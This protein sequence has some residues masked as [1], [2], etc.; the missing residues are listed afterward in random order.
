MKKTLYVAIREVL[1]TITTKGFIFGVL[2]TPALILAFIFLIPR[3]VIKGPPKI[4]GQVAIVDPTGDVAASL[5]AYLTPEQFVERR[6]RAQQQIRE[7]AQNEAGGSAAANAVLG[8]SLNAT[9]GEVPQIST[10]NLAIGCDLEKEKIP[11]KLP[12][13]KRA[14]SPLPR[15]ALVVIH[16]DAVRRDIAKETFGS[17]D[18]FVRSKL[19]DRL[20]DEIHA[21]IREAI[22]AARLRASG[23]D[24]KLVND[25]TKVER[26][27]SR[28]ITAEGEQ[29]SNRIL[30]S[31]LPI[32][33]MVLL[34]VSVLTSASSLLTTTIE[35]KSNRVVELLLSAVSAMELMTGKILGQMAVGLLIL[36]LYTGLGMVG[37]ASFAMVGLLDPMLLAYLVVFFI[38]AYFTVAALMAAVGSAVSELRDA[39]SLMMPVMVVFMVPWLLMAPISSQPNSMLAV[40]LSFVPPIGDFVMLL[41]M[42]SNTPPP[43]W[44]SWLAILVGAA[45]VYVA[46]RFASKVFRVGLLMFGKPPTFG[47][48]IRWARMA[49]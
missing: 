48:L 11:L 49:D 8:G 31:I 2:L 18:L 36:V 6:A 35:E 24:P 5:T 47:T 9:R 4:V 27:P 7:L 16:P 25:L 34:L 39:Q 28:V 10:V 45:G 42:A 3:L 29:K 22:G 30:N 19:D 32:A 37:L 20:V 44:Q 12:I 46:L 14:G 13:S 43:I 1:A 38:L 17:Y 15:L 21:G 33:F 26:A 40:I 41:R 23:F